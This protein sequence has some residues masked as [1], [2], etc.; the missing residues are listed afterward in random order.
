MVTD[1]QVRRLRKFYQSTGRLVVA[2][3]KAGMSEKTA[4][5]YVRSQELPSEQGARVRRYRTRPDPFE[6]VWPEVEKLLEATSGLRAVTIFEYLRRTD[7]GRFQDG[8]L[9]TLQRRIKAWRTTSG[10]A[11]EV[12]FPQK[13]T[14]GEMCQ[15][16]FTHM[17]KL[18]V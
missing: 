12:F 17:S 3:A 1:Q 4:R 5:K 16:D 11:R 9:R 2:A 7:P 15:S 18:G 10:P 8:Q 6:D 14:P 13:H